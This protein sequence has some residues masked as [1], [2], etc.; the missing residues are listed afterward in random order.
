MSNF[1]DD[2]TSL[3]TGKSDLTPV[4]GGMAANYVA[5]AEWQTSMQA[6]LDLRGYSFRK[7][8]G[9]GAALTDASTGA[10]GAAV[11]F[12]TLGSNTD[13]MVLGSNGNSRDTPVASIAFQNTAIAGNPIM[14]RGNPYVAG[15]GL[16]AEALLFSDDSMIVSGVRTWK[17]IASHE[18]SGTFA[19]VLDGVERSSYEAFIQNGDFKPWMRLE[20][21]SRGF[22]VGGGGCKALAG[23][24][25]RAANVVTVT[26]VNPHRF[27]VGDALWKTSDPY[28]TAAGDLTLF[29][30]DATSTSNVVVASV[31][32]ATSFTYAST[33][34]NGTST[35]NILYSGETD[36]TFGRDATA[37]AAVRVNGSTVCQFSP[38]GIIVP[39]GLSVL[40]AGSNMQLGAGGVSSL[41]LTANMVHVQNGKTFYQQG[42]YQSTGWYNGGGQTQTTQEVFIVGTGSGAQTTYLRSITADWIRLMVKNEGQGNT[43]NLTIQ[44]Y[45]GQ[46]IDGQAS[47]TIPA[48][49]AVTLVS[50]GTDWEVFYHDS[51]KP[52]LS[53]STSSGNAMISATSID[54][55]GYGGLFAYSDIGATYL[56]CL[57]STNGAGAGIGRLR[58]SLNVTGGLQIASGSNTNGIKLMV[59]NGSAVDTLAVRID[60]VTLATNLFGN[61]NAPTVQLGSSTAL[62]TASSAYEGMMWVVLGAGGVADVLSICLKAAGGSYSWKTI[63][64]G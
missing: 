22:N 32:S 39:A 64:T 11:P 13:L 18:Q 2:M 3:P 35:G 49:N 42:T 1:I 60:P 43:N 55:N 44:A 23:N 25:T 26:T 48:N 9:T 8:S 50:T 41:E 33:G 12:R 16:V 19:V 40:G 24:V 31:P 34:S 5:A 47:I 58:T 54:A 46:T 63:A 53:R 38:L 51:V 28:K 17:I 30:A 6:L 10:A 37:L 57:G 14:R 7:P 62:P 4:P 20:A 61:L 36:V 27:S 59:S 45:S 56:Q 29:G 21:S 15:I 52:N